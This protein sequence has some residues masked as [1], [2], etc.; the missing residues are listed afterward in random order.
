MK[1]G[2]KAEERPAGRSAAEGE[3]AAAR[4][5]CCGGDEVARPHCS[6]SKAEERARRRI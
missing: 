4:G 6:S 2:C 3:G 1:R 5:A